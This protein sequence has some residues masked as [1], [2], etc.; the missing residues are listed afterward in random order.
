MGIITRSAV[1][2]IAQV[3]FDLARQRRSKV[4]I[5]HKA[6]VLKLTTGLFRDVCR[7][8]AADYPDVE[9]DDFH[10]DAMTVHLVRSADK[11]DVI[12][13][14]N[15]FGDILSDLAGEIAGSLGI[16]PSFNASWIARHGPGRPRLR[17]RH[18]RARHRQPDRDD[19][20]LGD[21]ARVA[22]RPPRRAAAPRGRRA[23]RDRRRRHRARGTMTPDMGGPTS[24]SSFGTAVAKTILGG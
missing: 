2:K 11:F 10:I 3:A 16:A 19:P 17:T 21:A 22:R 6:N 4:T 20:V 23:D 18:R 14:E 15:M 1:E 7:E 13:T 9:L 5:V 24:T 8:I 12:V